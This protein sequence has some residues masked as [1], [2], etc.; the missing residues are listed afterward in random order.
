[1]QSSVLDK[2]DNPQYVHGRMGILGLAM[3][4][5]PLPDNELT[6]IYSAMTSD[7]GSTLS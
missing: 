3:F 1:M 7:W 5:E 2:T 6:G 4:A